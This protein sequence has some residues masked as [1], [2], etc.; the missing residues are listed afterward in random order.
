MAN[1][2]FDEKDHSTLYQKYMFSPPESIQEMIYSYLK[3]KIDEPF[4]LA[5]DVGCG[6]GKSTRLLANYFHKVVGIDDSEAQINVAKQFSMKPNVSF[7]VCSAEALPFQDAS[8]DLVTASV[9]AHWFDLEKFLKEV[10]RVLKP[11]GCLAVHCFNEDMDLHYENDPSE[12][13]AGI[14]P[15]VWYFLRNIHPNGY[16]VIKSKYKDIFNA[17]PFPEKQIYTNIP[18]ILPLSLPEVMGFIE[19][20]CTYQYYFR[21]NSEAAKGFLEKTNERIL[22]AIEGLPKEGQFELRKTHVCVLARKPLIN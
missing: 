6:T 14:L 5:V 9:S 15:E 11:N 17:I 22:E 1:R 18:D 16:A 19:S 8:V 20:A 12:R 21:Q 13:L 2:Y 10:R 4:G 3:E 7:C